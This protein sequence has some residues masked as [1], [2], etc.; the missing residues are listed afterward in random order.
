MFRY[1]LSGRRREGA[2]ASDASRGLQLAL[3]SIWTLAVV[4]VG[5][6]SR[7]ADSL[8]QRPLNLVG[9]VVHCMVVGIV[10]LVVLTLVEMRIEPWR[11]GGE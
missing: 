6:W 5:Y 3:W 4:L 7:H 9:L 11:F 8:A 2:A 1:L 10:G